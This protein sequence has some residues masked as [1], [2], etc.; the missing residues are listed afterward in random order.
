VRGTASRLLSALLVA[1]GL[2][3]L[4]A[5]ATLLAAG[6]PDAKPG[7]APAAEATKTADPPASGPPAAGAASTGTATPSAGSTGSATT[8]APEPAR[9]RTSDPAPAGQASSGAKRRAPKARVAAAGSVTIMDFKFLPSAITVHV[10][11]TVTWTNKGRTPHSAT[12]KGGSFD[13][14]VFPPGTSRSQSFSKAG[15]FS[16]FC[17][18]HPFMHGT[19]RVVGAASGGAGSAKS[20]SSGSPSSA[21]SESASGSGSSSGSS[22][23][24]TP[25]QKPDS[26][27]GSGSPGSSAASGSGGS[28]PATGFD[29]GLAAAVGAALVAAGVALRRRTREQP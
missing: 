15:T 7:S 13:T 12:A 1:L 21:G 5:P 29:A 16:Y 23:T 28:L 17:S 10:G 18:V 24:S 8:P 6:A 9:G 11:D 4:A 3:A 22:S 14:G 19:V 27:G 25:G 26:S 2:Q 20:G